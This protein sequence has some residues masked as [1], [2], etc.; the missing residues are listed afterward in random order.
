M[1]STWG[2][3]WGAI[4]VGGLP[5]LVDWLTGL[6]DLPFVAG[7]RGGPGGHVGIATVNEVAIGVVLVAVLVFEPGGIDAVLRRLR[8]RWGGA[9]SPSRP[10]SD[11]ERP[12]P[13]KSD[14][15]IVTSSPPS[16]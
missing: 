2:P 13:S 3:V 9:T 15:D 6:F 14:P 16:R 5:G 11:K 10:P 1:G 4:A 7:D 8:R 12:C